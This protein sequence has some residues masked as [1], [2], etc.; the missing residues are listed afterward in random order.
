MAL[1]DVFQAFE[2]ALPGLSHAYGGEHVAENAGSNRLVWVPSNDAFA[3]PVG[4][5]INPAP[6]YSRRAGCQLYIWGVDGGDRLANYRATEALLH[7]AI[8][9]L[10]DIAKADLQLDGVSWGMLEEGGWTSFGGGCVLRFSV[11]LPVA[12]APK[13]EAQVT[14]TEISSDVV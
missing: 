12:A 11:G 4:P 2:K 6:L 7:L 3:A 5:R 8:A 10:K 9:T 14:K 1:V 13:R